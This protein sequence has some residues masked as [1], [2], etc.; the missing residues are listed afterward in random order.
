M[1]EYLATCSFHSSRVKHFFPYVKSVAPFLLPALRLPESLPRVDIVIFNCYQRE[2]LSRPADTLHSL[3]H[4]YTQLTVIHI[5]HKKNDAHQK[6]L[7]QRTGKRAESGKPRSTL[8][9]INSNT[10]GEIPIHSERIRTAFSKLR[11]PKKGR[12]QAQAE[13][14]TK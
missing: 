7:L 4:T 5:T 14:K 3:P 8:I 10:M 1:A 11:D 13:R 12:T 9:V 2:T 6:Y